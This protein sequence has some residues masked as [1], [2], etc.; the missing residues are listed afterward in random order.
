MSTK[1]GFSD[2]SKAAS[3]RPDKPYNDLPPLP[4][5]ID[6]ETKAVLR[7]CITARASLAELK[8]AAELI[9]NQ[10]MLINTIPL[11]E[12]K[13]SSENIVTTADSLFRQAGA[14]EKADPPTKEALRYRRALLTGYKALKNRPL[15]TR[16]AES[17]CTGIRGIEMTVRKVAGTALGNRATGRVIYTPPEGER[18]LRDLL[19]N[20]ERFLHEEAQVDPLIRMAA[21]HY[22][23]EAI[24]PFTDGNGRT[25]RILNVLF[26]IQEGLISL[27]I[28]YLSRYITAHKADYYRLLLGVTREGAWEAWILY[29]LRGVEETAAWTTAKIAAIRRLAEHT[30]EFVRSA[31]P[32]IYSRDLI[33]VIFEQPYCRIAFLE[34]AGIAKRQ[35]ASRYLKAL[36][37]IGV[38]REEK[39]G[40]ERLFIHSK[41]MALLTRES[42]KFTRY[43]AP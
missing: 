10:A 36:A 11:L 17:V 39:S 20:W 1:R 18:K 30:T 6:L 28:L 3:W 25:G 5:A 40:R 16:T 24:H 35:A 14:D 7:R 33:D 27:P 41:L 23:F 12:A 8:Q 2:M 32:K 38:L 19:G 15:S 26:L 13:A 9:P 42:A 31:L 43:G 34:R 21:A 29:M 37:G 22:Q 4:P